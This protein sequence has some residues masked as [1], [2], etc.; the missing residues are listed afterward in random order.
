[1]REEIQ[2][3]AYN[4]F[5]Y[6]ILNRIYKKIADKKTPY[7]EVLLYNNF[8]CRSGWITLLPSMANDS[9][10]S[11]PVLGLVDCFTVFETL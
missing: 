11:Y 3:F 1:V 7:N 2:K 9:Q 4:E 10:L 6:L 8:E 5:W